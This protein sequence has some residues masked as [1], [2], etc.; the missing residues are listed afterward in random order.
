MFYNSSNITY[1]QY[2]THANK[3]PTWILLDSLDLH[4]V[5]KMIGSDVVNDT[6]ITSPSTV[7]VYKN[8]FNK[9]N[10]LL[11]ICV[12]I[13]LLLILGLI[14]YLIRKQI[15]RRKDQANQD[16]F[17]VG[18]HIPSAAI[19]NRTKMVRANKKTEILSYH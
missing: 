3:T 13:F 14:T 1:F 6:D 5:K 12:V 10:L 18:H 16:R 4:S 7:N 11:P 19:N 17:F 15:L 8:I 9:M 2:R